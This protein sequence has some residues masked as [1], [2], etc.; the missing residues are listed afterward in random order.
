MRAH[1]VS[2]SAAQTVPVRGYLWRSISPQIRD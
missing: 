2:H 1:L